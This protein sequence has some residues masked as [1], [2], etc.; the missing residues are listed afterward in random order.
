M[1]YAF[2]AMGFLLLLAGSEALLRGGAGLLRAFDISPIFI[3]LLVVSLAMTAPELSIALQATAQ[4]VPDIA[5]GDIIGSNIANL[6]L[7]FGAGAIL[8]P[9]PGSPKV[10]FRDGGVLIVASAFL[11]FV[12]LGG[13]VGRSVGAI[14]LVGWLGY[15]AL[16]YVTDWGRAPQRLAT[17]T[18]A[19]VRG[20]DYGAG[21]SF[22]LAVIGIVCL[23]FGARFA[24]D[25][26]VVI[27]RDFHVSQTAVA[28]TLIALG[29]TLPELL[30]A[31]GSSARG[32]SS[33]VSGHLIASGIF[34]ILLVFAVTVIVRPM[35]IAPM[36]SQFDAP[37]M[38]GCALV[39]SVFL[40]SGWRLSRFQGVLLLAGYVAYIASVAVRSGVRFHF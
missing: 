6:L 16:T 14:L 23:F 32:Q 34:N 20:G 19:Q 11:A 1:V 24:I 12:M 27:A 8:R 33:F 5:L 26:A 15:L 22:F 37:V 29:T 4:G 9:M 10:V 17:E 38:T 2:L 28:L 40:L 30:V 39:V 35:A 21:L 13:F 18:H 36:L 25:L 3:G 31:L 7:V